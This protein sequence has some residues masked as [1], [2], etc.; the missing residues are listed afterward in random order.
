MFSPQLET[1][2]KVKWSGKSNVKFSF[3]GNGYWEGAKRKDF[4]CPDSNWE[5]RIVS[6]S[7]LRLWTIQYSIVLGFQLWKNDEWVN[8][9][10]RANDF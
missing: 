10:C 7:K 2:K 3:E 8:V 4:W 6:G 5:K 9:W 1:I